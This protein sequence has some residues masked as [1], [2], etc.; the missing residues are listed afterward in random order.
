[1]LEG[2]WGLVGRGIVKVSP[3]EA[4]RLVAEGGV[5]VDVRAPLEFAAGHLPGAINFPV[6]EVKRRT[7]ELR[8][9]EHPLVIYCSAGMRCHKVAKILRR[10]GIEDVHE[11]GWMSRW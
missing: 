4:H 7:E 2:F 8:Q 1:M 10:A 11:L 3:E 9:I 6:D 5:L